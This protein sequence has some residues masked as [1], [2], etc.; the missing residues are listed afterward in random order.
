MSGIPPSTNLPKIQKLTQETGHRRRGQ[1]AECERAW[2]KD[3]FLGFHQ[4]SEITAI[5]YI[6]MIN[7]K[8]LKIWETIIKIRNEGKIN[9]KINKIKIIRNG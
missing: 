7:L 8:E 9:I 5:I 4:F 3:N 6:L 1:Q 2:Q